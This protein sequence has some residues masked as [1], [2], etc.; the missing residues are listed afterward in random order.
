MILH[1][2]VRSNLLLQKAPLTVWRAWRAWRLLHFSVAGTSS[3]P[4]SL[5]RSE[6]LSPVSTEKLLHTPVMLKEVL[7]FLNIQPGQVC[8]P[9]LCKVF[10]VVKKV[11]V[12]FYV[13]SF[14]T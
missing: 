12:C 9:L 2:S 5:G 1:M 7:Y 13:L 4:G 6:E 3:G 10:D 11:K 8:L 14:R